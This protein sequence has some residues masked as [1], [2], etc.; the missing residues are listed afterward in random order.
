[1]AG[2]SLND[3]MAIGVLFCDQ[4]GST[5][6]LTR[7]GDDLNEEL[8]RDFRRQPIGLPVSESGLMAEPVTIPVAATRHD[9][10]DGLR[11]FVATP[12]GR[13]ARGLLCFR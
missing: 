1:V 6:L 3:V 4:V 8:R 2:G 7:L 9:L 12:D 10:G 5:A 13:S 11:P